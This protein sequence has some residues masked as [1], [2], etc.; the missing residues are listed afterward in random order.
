MSQAQALT[1][2]SWTQ[3]PPRLPSQESYHQ[4]HLFNQYQHPKLIRLSLRCH[5]RPRCHHLYLNS[6]APVNASG[7]T[8]WSIANLALQA[9]TNTIIITATDAVG[10]IANDTITVTYSVLSSSSSWK[11]FYGVG[12]YGGVNESISYAKQMGYDYLTLVYN[13]GNRNLYNSNPNRAGA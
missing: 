9:G 11:N 5:K 8:T 4:R 2:L 6:A 12:W 7:L 1:L 3:P 10:N 13:N